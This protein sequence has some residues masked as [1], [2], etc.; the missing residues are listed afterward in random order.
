[1]LKSSFRLMTIL[2]ATVVFLTACEKEE[3]VRLSAT[4]AKESLIAVDATLSA[5][6]NN[7]SNA[8]GFKALEQLASLTNGGTLFTTARIQDARK[9]PS[10]YVRVGIQNLQSIISEASASGRSQGDEPF[11]YAE[12]KGVYTWNPSLQDFEFTSQSN[13]VE[14]RFPTEGSSTNNAVFRLTNYAEVETPFGDEP[15]SPTDIEATLDINNVKQASLS[16]AAEYKSDGTDDPVFADISYFVSPYT[17]D[18]NLDDTK[19]SIS[20]FSQY[21]SKNND[22]LIGWALTAS[23][24]GAKVESNISKLEGTVQLASAIFTIVFTA[25]TDPTAVP[26]I[27][28]ILKINVTVDGKIAGKIIWVTEAGALEP[29][30]YIQYNDG[31]QQKL[32][33]LF[34]LLEAELNGLTSIA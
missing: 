11:N 20:T 2:F 25:P 22:K 32:S 8:E 14:L 31:S 23:Y 16:L 17:L 26:D 21:L 4:D 7:F 30:P 1:M 15:Y 5:E 6:L 29:S 9:N 10:A 19:P 12:H 28:D 34:E 24:K 3:T 13:I 27:N 18:I 33:E